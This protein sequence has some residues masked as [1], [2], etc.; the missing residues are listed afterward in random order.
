MPLSRTQTQWKDKKNQRRPMWLYKD[1]LTYL[2]N[3]EL[4]TGN[5]RKSVALRKYKKE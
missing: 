4:G 5:R 1:L 2:K 3:Q